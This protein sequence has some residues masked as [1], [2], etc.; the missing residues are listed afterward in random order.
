MTACLSA[1]NLPFVRQFVRSLIDA[2]LSLFLVFSFTEYA[3][4]QT[5][6]T[7]D[8][9]STPEGWAWSQIK[10]GLPADFGEF[11]DVELD[12]TKQDDPRWLKTCRTISADFIVNLLTRSSLHDTIKYKGA[13]L[14]NARIVGVVDLRF[15]TIDRPLAIVSSR[16]EGAMKLDYARAD[17]VVTF[18]KSLFL[19]AL[20]GVGFGSETDVDFTQTTILGKILLDKARI[21]GDLIMSGANFKDDLKASEIEIHGSLL[22]LA[23]GT[24]KANFKNVY[25]N[26][27]TVTGPVNM[28][29]ASLSGDLNAEGLRVEASL[30]MSS[31]DRYK[32]TFRN[33]RLV[34][35]ETRTNVELVGASVTG[36]LNASG[37]KV[38]GSLLMHPLYTNESKFEA[39][40]KDTY[41]VGAKVARSLE[42]NQASFDGYLNA[43][44]IQIGGPLIAYS[45]KFKGINVGLATIGG[46]VNMPNSIFDG[47]AI[48][49][50]LHV[51]GD[52]SLINIE[53]NARFDV[54]TAQ[55]GGDLD[56]RGAK[57][58]TVDLGGASIVG[59]LRLGDENSK[60]TW[61]APKNG[62]LNLRNAHVGSL[63]DN[64]ESWP[65]RLFLDGFS[66][67]HFGSNS[68]ASG[69][70]MTGRPA[71]WW[72]EH[73]IEH[74]SDRS[75]W[76]YEELTAIF[77]AAGNRDAADDIRFDERVWAEQKTMG[78]G[79]LWSSALR[80]GAG[81][82]IGLYMF[83][84]LYWALGWAVIGAVF[85]RFIAKKGVVELKSKNGCCNFWCCVW[86]FGASV[87]RLLP[88][89][90]L[91]KE[92]ADFFDDP[93]L[94]QFRP[95]QDLLSVVFAGIGWVL[96]AIVIAAFATITHGP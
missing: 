82:G 45:A 34:N 33:V 4:S 79:F 50:S 60:V 24:S 42:L 23:E 68:G 92:F 74:D 70:E 19:D 52:V 69:G 29:G 39:T 14:V 59:D 10:Q 46:Q 76:P 84:A 44:S 37:L 20:S 85:L 5:P 22:M 58:E 3:Q 8:D 64:K 80:L 57:L 35:A 32:A 89:L 2:V 31:D 16:F 51:F 43:E 9:V 75:S 53:S 77:T 63:S 17:S 94:N 30:F 90:S 95:W 56:F 66:F 91:K 96:G 87:N 86:C 71:A 78:F 72:N 65:K 81:Y 67:G 1:Q 21:K 25:L 28:T 15:A 62:E 49:K 55:I 7:Y 18:K 41:M 54:S 26:F 88:V 27:A 11:C 12:P 47:D 38:G 48:L 6:A 93:K 36:Q 83:R 73:F 61:L 40:F 13:A